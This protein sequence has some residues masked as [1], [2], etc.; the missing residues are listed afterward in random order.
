MVHGFE[1]KTWQKC[2]KMWVKVLVSP[3][4]VQRCWRVR[5][6]V[7]LS[8]NKERFHKAW[9][10]YFLLTTLK[11]SFVSSIKGS[12][13]MKWNLKCTKLYELTKKIKTNCCDF[14]VKWQD[15]HKEQ[16]DFFKV[17]GHSESTSFHT[18]PGC[19]SAQ[20]FLMFVRERCQ[21]SGTSKKGLTLALL[22]AFVLTIRCH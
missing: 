7:C 16:V 19:G 22:A 8:P 21:S 9:F 20:A 18:N 2:Q 12:N 11:G 3:E 14:V 4:G 5:Q 1:K 15:L 17:D 10:I 13:G 6:A